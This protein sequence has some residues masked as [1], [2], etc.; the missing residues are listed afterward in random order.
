MVLTRRARRDGGHVSLALEHSRFALLDCQGCL[1]LVAD[2]VSAPE[3]AWFFALVCR[4]FAAAMHDSTDAGGKLRFPAGAGGRRF[5]T[6]D[7]GVCSSISR[8]IWVRQLPA[9]VPAWPVL[10]PG[11]DPTKPPY[12]TAS[13]VVCSRIAQHGS[14]PALLWA[15]AEGG[16]EWKHRSAYVSAGRGGRLAVLQWMRGGG[17]GAV[18]GQAD[19]DIAAASAIDGGHCSV[20]RW[21]LDE[22]I[23]VIE[24]ETRLT[25][26]LYTAGQ[27]GHENL[28]TLL[29]DRGAAVD[30]ARFG[31][32]PLCIAAE[33][34]HVAMVKLL[35][36]RGATVN[37]ANA[38]GVTSLFMAAQN[39]HNRLAELLLDRGAAVDQEMNNGATPLF[40]AAQNG[41]DR[42]AKLL[43]DRGAAVNRG[44]DNGATPLFQ[45]AQ[46]GHNRLA[47]LL[48]DRGADVD[49]ARDNGATPLLVAAQNGH[50]RLA[51]LL[52]SRGAAV[53]R[54]RAQHTL[55]SCFYY[56]LL[57][58]VEKDYV[59]A[60]KWYRKAA[61]Q[62][63][64]DAQY[65]LGGCYYHGN[66]VHKD[67]VEAAKWCRK[68]AEQGH[69]SAQHY[70]GGCYYHGDGVDKDKEHSRA[71]QALAAC[72]RDGAG[73]ERDEAAAGRWERRR[74]SACR[75]Q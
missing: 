4:D 35:L 2:Q 66:G 25:T 29:L 28:A 27:N 21:M 58:R 26:W 43:L 7:T 38:N 46:N 34:G 54:S 17:G 23:V 19:D 10:A 40:Q 70:L 3:D 65:Y 49:R 11:Q 64:S 56:G 8:V 1:G 68:A 61:D 13:T 41:H 20:V 69:R 16:F 42:L 33:M 63:H 47:E 9:Y 14:L 62:G 24:K 67:K 36:D 55:G 12:E 44:M 60:A 59:E 73:V 30:L 51:K 32:T 57:D 18:V 71:M 6:S 52:L 22:N 48:L 75:S 31:A 15:R 39:G 72:Y 50:D 45:A 37:L 5:V 53:N 74:R